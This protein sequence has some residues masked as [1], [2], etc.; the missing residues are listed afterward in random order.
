MVYG[1]MGRKSREYFIKNDTLWLARDLIGKHLL[2][3]VDGEGVCGGII[4]ETEAYMGPEDRASHARGNRNTKRTAVMFQ[5][6]GLSY[7]YL[8]YGIHHLFNIVTNKA[9]TPHAIL[10]RAI[11]PVSGILT[12]ENRVN[13]RLPLLFNGP[14]VLTRAMGIKTTHT[15]VQLDGNLIWIEDK[16]LEIP[17]NL[18]VA[19]QRIGVDYAGEDALLPWRFYIKPEDTV[20]ILPAEE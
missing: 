18:I 8:C 16:G 17:Q 9:G 20:K 2:A 6:G 5:E 15:G 3:N 14:G 1:N 4:T 13:K 11:K 10:I 7:V 12:M 19:G